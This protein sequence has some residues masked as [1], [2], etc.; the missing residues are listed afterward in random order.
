MSPKYWPETLT[1]NLVAHYGKVHW[2]TLGRKNNRTAGRIL[3]ST[4]PLA[5]Y[6]QNIVLQLDTSSD[7]TPPRPDTPGSESPPQQSSAPVPAGGCMSPAAS[8]SASTLGHAVPGQ[9]GGAWE[10]ARESRGQ[11][12]GVISSPDPKTL[13]RVSI[14]SL[15]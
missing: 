4:C 6:G 2:S 15:Q 13:S 12:K 9:G 14:R 8:G 7:L 1:Y 5:H 3:G 11:R 10:R